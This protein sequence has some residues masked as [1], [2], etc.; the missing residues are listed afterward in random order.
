MKVIKAKKVLRNPKEV[1]VVVFPG[2]EGFVYPDLE[3]VKNQL[4]NQQNAR[5]FKAV[6]YKF[7][8]TLSVKTEAHN[9]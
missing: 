8:A 5:L 7:T 3:A 4:Y 1:W 6:E 9:G 2:N